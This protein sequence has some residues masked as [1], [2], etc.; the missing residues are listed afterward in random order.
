MNGEKIVITKS[1]V[2]VGTAEKVRQAIAVDATHSFHV[3]SNPE[4]LKEGAAV[5]DFMKP[6]R[7]VLG[8]TILGRRRC[9]ARFS[10]RSSGRATRS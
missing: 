3:C 4:F 8:V 1:T 2:P 5:E 10:N 9:S 7:V 6:D